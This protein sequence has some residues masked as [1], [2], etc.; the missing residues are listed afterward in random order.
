MRLLFIFGNLMLKLKELG[1]AFRI[2]HG[3]TLAELTNDSLKAIPKGVLTIMKF[4]KAISFTY[5]KCVL[6]HCLLLVQ[7][8]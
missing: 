4:I 8:I 5:L 3:S 7:I 1:C 2:K 6:M